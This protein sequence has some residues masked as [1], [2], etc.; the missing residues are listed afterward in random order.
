LVFFE[1]SSIKDEVLLEKCLRLAHVFK[2]SSERIPDFKQ[3]FPKINVDLEIQT[4][5]S[6]GLFYR[7]I[8]S[9]NKNKWKKLKSFPA[10]KIIDAAG[11]G[12]WCSAGIIAN[13][14][15]GGSKSFN[16]R[17][18]RA[19]ELALNYGQILG[20]LNCTLDGARGLMYQYSSS[21]L[22]QKVNK[23]LASK[24]QV[25]ISL[26]TNTKP[27]IDISKAI[28]ISSLY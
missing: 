26:N 16:S 5:G 7:T 12:D 15:N 22:K 17:G 19:I 9:T 28:T 23:Y 10:K 1:P 3:R 24:G 20:S 6:E 27:L 21:S 14:A 25:T 4:N 2:F 8:K 13:L 11:A 18:V